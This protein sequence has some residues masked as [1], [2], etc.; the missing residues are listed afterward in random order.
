VGHPCRVVSVSYEQMGSGQAEGAGSGPVVPAI[1][2]RHCPVIV[3]Q[4]IRSSNRHAVPLLPVLPWNHHSLYI[5][6]S[7]QVDGI[8]GLKDTM[9][10]TVPV[11]SVRIGYRKP[12]G[13]PDLSG[14]IRELHGHW[15]ASQPCD[16]R[17]PAA[18][19]HMSEKNRISGFALRIG[20]GV[21]NE[22]RTNRTKQL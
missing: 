1:Q 14:Q 13:R 5:E 17:I 10:V 16:V 3:R 7:Y 9:Q 21:V 18:M 6:R 12:R 22:Q 2:N 4:A 11:A 8:S 15:V 19:I 20:M